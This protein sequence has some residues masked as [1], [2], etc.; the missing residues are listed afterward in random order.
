MLYL[1]KQRVERHSNARAQRAEIVRKRNMFAANEQHLG[2]RFGAAY[3]LA[4]RLPQDA[5]R[6]FDRTVVRVMA[7]DEGQNI[8]NLLPSRNLPIG[9][10]VAEY[11]IASD[12]GEGRAS[13]TG[14]RAHQLDRAAYEY[15]GAL[16][17]IHDDGFGRPW[18]EVEGMRS[19]D[20]DAL[21]DDQA[22]SVRAVS[23]SVANHV[24]L[25][26]ADVEYK[27]RNAS[28]MKTHPN[29]QDLDLGTSGQN[30]DLTAGATSFADIESA[31]IAALNVL[32]GR[33]NNVMMDIT[34][35]VSSEIWS[36]LR[37]RTTNDGEYLTF[38]EGLKRIPGVADI[39]RTNG[40]QLTGNEFLA[41]ANGEQYIQIQTG[42][43]VNTQPVIRTQFNDD[44]NF[45][46]WCAS[47]L[48]VKRDASGRSG[49]LYAREIT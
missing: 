32:Q 6:E 27:E 36:N 45:I 13:I 8:I 34:F 5:Y 26:V 21:Q 16:V 15:D 44:F 1:N 39:V 35:A 19:E 25:G 37:R 20:F 28:G 7:G 17:L 43:V 11:G 40:D 18:R 3:N 24:I 22:N 49:V 33:S 29:T 2:E 42:M 38:L 23:R 9:K 30:V 4:A 41:W 10:I 47:G 46:T 12:S 31:F 14:R 48:L